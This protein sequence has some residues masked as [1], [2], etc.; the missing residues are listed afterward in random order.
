MRSPLRAPVEAL[1]RRPRLALSTQAIVALALLL[2]VVVLGSL[3]ASTAV[4]RDDL[5]KQYEQRA[6]A[7]ARSMA[8]SPGLARRV[9]RGRPTVEGPVQREAERVRNATGALY[10]V[11]TDDAGIR[12]SHP[13]LANI[14][15]PVSTSPDEVLAGH[16]VVKIERGT[17]GYSAR[18]KVPLRDEAGAVIGEV[19]VGIAISELDRETHKLVVLLGLVALGPLAVGLA[20]AVLLGRRLRRTTL[21]LEPEEMADLV[22]EHAAVLGGVRDGVL[23]VDPAGRITVANAEA[24]RLLGCDLPRG[25]AL[26]D[27]GAG[28]EVLALLAEEPPPTGALRVL[29]GRVVLVTRLAVRRD[30]RDLG[31]VLTLR[32]RTDLDEL[33]R[34]LEATR[35]LTDALRAQAHE[36]SNRLHTLTGLLHHG[37]LAEA[38]EYL[39][40]LSEASTWV[41]GVDDP[42]LAGLLAAK[43]AAASEAGVALVVSDASW[44]DGRLAHPLDTVT[45]VANL[46]DNGIRAA[47]EG[48]RH[49]RWVEV[50]LLGDG[51]DLVVH[52]VDSGDGVPEAHAGQLFDHGFTTRPGDMPGHGLGLALA[53]HT[54]R[55]HGGDVRLVDGGNDDHGA[56]FEARLAS[57]LA[58]REAREEGLP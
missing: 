40:G 1:R 14:G 26:T 19:S 4:L 12:F 53:R 34:E 24:A 13:T 17:L 50:T 30:R 39:S 57:A 54:A 44:V 25:A 15:K 9:A 47:A 51:A 38:G 7:I 41:S 27:T 48:E 55:A 42:Y 5:E 56:A 33:G 58:G 45:V 3:A 52:V 36:H 2:V 43:S 10:V 16:E 21:G 46:L 18:G 35:A 28:P 32:D 23:G 6:L 31:T 8:S 29:G 20:G 37:D 11:V 22:R 49:P